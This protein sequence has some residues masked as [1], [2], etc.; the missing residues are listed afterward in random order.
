MKISKEDMAKLELLKKT[1]PHLDKIVK[2]FK[3]KFGAKV[4]YIKDDDIDLEIGQR[5]EGFIPV[6]MSA[7]CPLEERRK[8]RK[9]NK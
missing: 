1:K 7:N 3:E 4:V 5:Y 8:K 6:E 2:K 9:K